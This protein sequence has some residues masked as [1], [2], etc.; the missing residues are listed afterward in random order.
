MVGSEEGTR[1]GSTN[2][3]APHQPQDPP[4]QKVVGCAVG[5]Q[6]DSFTQIASPR[7]RE[8]T[9]PYGGAVLWLVSMEKPVCRR[10]GTHL[11]S[12]RGTAHRLPAAA[13]DAHA[14]CLALTAASCLCAPP[15]RA[16]GP[17]QSRRITL[18]LCAYGHPHSRGE[19]GLKPQPPSSTE[20]QTER[21]PRT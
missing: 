21:R 11:C 18:C 13:R 15:Y 17:L 7:L 8:R 9:C 5:E 6:C 16:F 14:L 12:S 19:M 20:S 1:E 3:L 4:G 2:C 10:T